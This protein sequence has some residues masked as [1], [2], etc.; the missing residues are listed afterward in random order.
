MVWTQRIELW[1]TG[2]LSIE[3]WCTGLLPIVHV[4]RGVIF[5]WY[6]FNSLPTRILNLRDDEF[7]FKA[8]L[9]KYL[10]FIL[11]IQL[12]NFRCTEGMSLMAVIYNFNLYFVICTLRFS[13]SCPL[14][15][16]YMFCI[17]L[18]N[19]NC[20]I[21]SCFVCIWVLYHCDLFDFQLSFLIYKMYVLHVLY[22]VM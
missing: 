17:L 7:H 15:L 21:L 14:K 3:L 5:C 12:L 20:V 6:I 10:L 1:C 11:F 18:C 22:S 8:A 16:C 19:L 4:F 13:Y 2:L 9:W